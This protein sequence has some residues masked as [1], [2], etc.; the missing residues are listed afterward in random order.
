[1][2]TVDVTV[3]ANAALL[4]EP[5]NRTNVNVRH[6]TTA[7]DDGSQ[8]L[9]A[10]AVQSLDAN[11]DPTIGAQPQ[12]SESINQV[13]QRT[14]DCTRT[15][16]IS[17]IL[18]GPT[19]GPL[20]VGWR[21][22]AET[23]TG[24]DEKPGVPPAGAALTVRAA[25][26]ITAVDRSSSAWVSTEALR[27]D[28]THPRF[29]RVITVVQPADAPTASVA[30][31]LVTTITRDAEDA[32]SELVN[33]RVESEDGE[34]LSSGPHGLQ[35]VP[36]PVCTDQGGCRTTLRVIG[37]WLGGPPASS[38]TVAWTFGASLFTIDPAATLSGARLAL[39]SETVVAAEIE[40]IGGTSGALIIGGEKIKSAT[41]EISIDGSAIRGSDG[42]DVFLQATMTATTTSRSGSLKNVLLR[43]GSTGASGLVGQSLAV[44]SELIPVTCGGRC[45]AE[46]PIRAWVYGTPTDDV[47]LDWKLDLALVHGPAVSIAPAPAVDF[48]VV[49][50]P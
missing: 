19:E 25:E 32:Y 7:G 6:T 35:D 48:E 30:G 31:L 28:A 29:E 1:M 38:A 26:P 13:C 18:A 8:P 9:V 11:G 24:T 46:I 12:L 20:K 17:A 41:I 37:D 49:A 21:T 4:T 39:E 14:G 10:V 23:R 33:V 40:R 43:I 34:R 47:T 5:T 22:V 45:T 42:R 2:A 16:R 3:V 27:L 15:Y 50:R 44:V 36:L